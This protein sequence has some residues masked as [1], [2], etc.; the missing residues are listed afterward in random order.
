M[1]FR[2]LNTSRKETYLVYNI[3]KAINLVLELLSLTWIEILQLVKNLNYYEY[4]F[5]HS[6]GA[7]Q[8][9]QIILNNN[10]HR[11]L[12]FKCKSTEDGGYIVFNCKHLVLIGIKKY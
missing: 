9:M 11:I 4:R 5:I 7:I 12:P 3:S 2:F 6:I 1:K 10:S 8:N